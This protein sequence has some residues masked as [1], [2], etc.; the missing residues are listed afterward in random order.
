MAGNK[1]WFVLRHTHY[2]P[3]T[4]PVGG[5]VGRSTGPLC[6]GH[7]VPDLKH[8]DNVINSK[9][10]LAF[11]PDMP[12]YLAQ[13]RNFSYE[14]TKDSGVTLSAELG[15]PIAAVA[16]ITAK[17][18]ASVAFRRSVS[19]FS[20]FKSVD[21]FLIQVNPSYI[22]D[23]PD[24]EE[25]SKY[26]QKYSKLGT[27]S[28]FM[29]TGIMI[30]RGGGKISSSESSTK[31]LGGGPGAELPA[32]AELDFNLDFSTEK[33]VSMAWEQETDFVWAIRV[34]KISKG[35]LDREWSFETFSQGA[36]FELGQQEV[37][38]KG[39]KERLAT[40]GLTSVEMI[41]AGEELF[42]LTVDS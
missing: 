1:C 17:G 41:D 25:V 14:S 12:V 7:L 30:A 6:P 35:F 31:G 27:W 21:T 24:S 36:V 28:I 23:T 34:A 29:V 19:N 22:E 33:A 18:S 20:A 3:P 2:P 13:T 38:E 9:G 10:P 26:V 15:I 11:P 42:V 32:I 5:G 37:H 4:F 40:E 8:L 39:V 16:G